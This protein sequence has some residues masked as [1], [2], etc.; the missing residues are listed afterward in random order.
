M[1][2]TVKRTLVEMSWSNFV[3]TTWVL[4]LNIKF[5]KLKKGRGERTRNSEAN[6]VKTNQLKDTFLKVPNDDSLASVIPEQKV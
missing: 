2:S 4:T 5:K 3:A 6:L 1:K